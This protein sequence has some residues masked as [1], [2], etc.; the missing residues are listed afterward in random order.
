[1]EERPSSP[2]EKVRA[3]ELVA[4]GKASALWGEGSRLRTLFPVWERLVSERGEFGF[5]SRRSTTIA[6]SAMVA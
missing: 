3:L 2:L 1:M 5:T 6:T 4:L